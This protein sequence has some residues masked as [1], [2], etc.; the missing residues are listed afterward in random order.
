[1][2]VDVT[3][4]RENRPVSDKHFK[5]QT[6]TRRNQAVLAKLGEPLNDMAALFVRVGFEETAKNPNLGTWDD[7]T[8]SPEDTDELHLCARQLRTTASA[9]RD[10]RPVPDEQAQ[11]LL[12]EVLAGYIEAGELMTSDDTTEFLS[13]LMA[14]GAATDTFER[15]SLRLVDAAQGD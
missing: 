7:I 13:G 2:S 3:A 5:V 14:K 8:M 6:W 12:T 15:F 9:L 11:A 10:L 4:Q 1:M